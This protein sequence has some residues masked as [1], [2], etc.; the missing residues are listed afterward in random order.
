MLDV[1]GDSITKLNPDFNALYSTSWLINA[2]QAIKNG[3]KFY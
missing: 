2:E 3:M 1:K